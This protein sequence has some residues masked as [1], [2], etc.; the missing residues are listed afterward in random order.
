VHNQNIYRKEKEQGRFLAVSLGEQLVDG[1][2]E[3]TLDYLIDTMD[4]SVFDARY[5]NDRTGAPAVNPAALLKIIRYCYSIRVISSRKIAAMCQYHI[6]VK[7]LSGNTEPHYTTISNFVST[8]GAEKETVF[9]E[10]LLVCHELKLIGGTMF[11]ID[12]CRQRGEGM[13]R[14][15]ERTGE[16]IPAAAGD[17]SCADEKTPRGGRGGENA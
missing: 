4:L 2:F 5:A 13:E 1:T 3:H 7:A 9:G 16:E 8:M 14:D 11:A 17:D 10:V 6:I 12:G 15:E